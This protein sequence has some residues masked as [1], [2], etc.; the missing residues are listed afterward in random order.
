MNINDLSKPFDANK[1]SWRVGATTKDKKKGIALAY[2]DAR[3]AMERLDECLGVAN[4]QSK[5]P[6]SDGGRIVCEIGVKID[7]EW[8][9]KANGAGS[10]QVEADKGAFSDSFKRACV[11]WGI[12]QYLYDVPNIWMPLNEY[13]AFTDDTKKELTKRLA[14]WQ[15]NY[16]KG[17][18]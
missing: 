16:F 8:V 9:W 18:S 17:K 14:A 11:L 2:I 3:D 12:G 6:W 4:W 10:T 13:K 15:V 7:Q 5:Y 1:I